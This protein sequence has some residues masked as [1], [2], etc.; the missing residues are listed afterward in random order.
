VILEFH[1]LGWLS[2]GRAA[3]GLGFA[4]D[5][6]AVE[7]VPDEHIGV[8]HRDA[9]RRRLTKI[10]RMVT[11]RQLEILEAVAR[12]DHPPGL[13]ARVNGLPQSEGLPA[14]RDALRA[15][16]LLYVPDGTE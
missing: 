9:A 16:R 4:A 7:E 10:R 11:P 1:R 6:V 3:A 2:P 5:I 13:W 15:V 8:E 14:F 12:D